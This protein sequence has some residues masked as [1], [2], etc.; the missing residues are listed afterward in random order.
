MTPATFNIEVQRNG[1]YRKTWSFKAPDGTPV[2]L[3]G[4]TYEMDI[5]HAAGDGTVLAS[6]TVALEGLASAGQISVALDGS[7]LAAV[8]GVNEIVRL[9]YDLLVTQSGVK[10]ILARGALLLTPGVS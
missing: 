6:F 5:K 10:M 9:A 1:S 2:D 8:D 7:A 4:A 3:T